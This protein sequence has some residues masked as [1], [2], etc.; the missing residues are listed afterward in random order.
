MYNLTTNETNAAL[1]L[2]KSCLSNMGGKRPI[3]L[4]SD[5]YTW[6][7]I[8]DLTSAGWSRHEAAGTFSALAA[9]GVIDIDSEGDTLNTEAYRWLDTI[10]S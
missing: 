7:S 8:D 2:V 9:K 10:W 4:D 5:P 1:T 6:I 3:D